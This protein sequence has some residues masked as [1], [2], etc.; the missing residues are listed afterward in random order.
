MPRPRSRNRGRGR[1]GGPRRFRLTRRIDGWTTVTGAGPTCRFGRRRSRNGRRNSAVNSM[2]R[3][4]TAEIHSMRPV[5]A[6]ASR[7]TVARIRTAARPLGLRFICPPWGHAP[8]CARTA[9]SPASPG[10]EI[11]LGGR[12]HEA[13]GAG[14]HCGRT[15]SELTPR[16]PARLADGLGAEGAPTRRGRRDSPRYVGSPAPPTDSRGVRRSLRPTSQSGWSYFI[17]PQPGMSRGAMDLGPQPGSPAL[18]T[19][20]TKTL[21]SPLRRVPPIPPPAD[22]ASFGGVPIPT[23]LQSRE[24]GEPGRQDVHH[25][26]QTCIGI[27][28]RRRAPKPKDRLP[29]SM[30]D[31]PPERRETGVTPQQPTPARS[32]C[33]SGRRAAGKPRRR[34]RR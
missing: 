25:P 34:R 23:R 15:G 8:R 16:T 5:R 33:R 31:R 19:T 13:G 9:N 21:R 24:L 12:P 30:K 29:F 2:A 6:N 18:S 1:R 20:S 32:R 22:G 3:N 7:L 4:R 10:R 11:E 28:S 17:T 27:D 14:R 26:A